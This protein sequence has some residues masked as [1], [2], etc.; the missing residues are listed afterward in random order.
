[1]STQHSSLPE[2]PLAQVKQLLCHDFD[3]GVVATSE[4]SCSRWHLMEKQTPL[5][6]V[7]HKAAAVSRHRRLLCADHS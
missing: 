1:M 2:W 5:E 6:S 4:F 7:L 3:F